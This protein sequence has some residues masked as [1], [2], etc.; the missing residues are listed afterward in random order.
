MGNK[1]VVFACWALCAQTAWA[2][3]PSDPLTAIDWLS[4]NIEPVAQKPVEPPVSQTAVTPEVSVAPLGENTRKRLGLLP[5]SVSGLAPSLWSDTSATALVR[6]LAPA[7]RQRLPAGQELLVTL[8][9]AEAD[10]LAIP[11]QALAW[12]VA[13]IESLAALGA[14]DPALAMV[15][16]ADPAETPQF[17]ERWLD[18]SLLSKSEAA[19]CDA[20]NATPTLSSSFAKRVYCKARMGDFDTASLL[21]GTAAAVNAF[22][23]TEETLLARFLDPDLFE[24][25]PMPRAPVRPDPLTFRLF[26]AAGAALPTTSLPT[27][28]AHFDL[29]TDVG[30][31]AQLEAAERLAR[32]GTLPSNRLLGLYTDRKAAASGG[33][34]DR[35]RTLQEFDAALSA[36]DS[37]AIAEKL[38]TIW[39]G[40]KAA[41]LQTPFSDLFAKPISAFALDDP[42]QHIAFQMMLLSRGFEGTSLPINAT[43]VDRFLVSVAAG[44]PAAEH[45]T[46]DMSKAVVDGFSDTSPASPSIETLSNGQIGEEMLRVLSKLADAGRSDTAALSQAIADLRALGLEDFARRAA[47]QALIL[48]DDG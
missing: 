24:D 22:S 9:L 29:S 14:I 35:V 34:W 31:K 19:A 13:R 1:G 26:E 6:L 20:L 8:L 41:D 45:A 40:M 27:M 39:R 3:A 21:F 46:T 4:E 48:L 25:D 10:D 16:Q 18:L 37:D 42:A 30:W 44:K 7:M 28:F 15:R 38:P 33:I 36:G 23:D 32:I 5:Q 2:Q 17:F 47:L 11:H 43:S 12:T